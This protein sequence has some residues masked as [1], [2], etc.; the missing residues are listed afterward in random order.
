MDLGLAR[1]AGGWL[2]VSQLAGGISEEGAVCGRQA[3]LCSWT[4][5]LPRGA[6]RT[7]E[8][9]SLQ[10]WRECQRSPGR[11]LYWTEALM[12]VPTS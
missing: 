1:R 7:A 12:T 5:D 4:R 2:G 10:S 9:P 8:R 6:G 3:W 11:R